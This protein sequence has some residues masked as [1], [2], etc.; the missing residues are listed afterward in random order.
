MIDTKKLLSLLIVT[1][2]IISI[3]VL[4]SDSDAALDD[5]LW[6]GDHHI[7]VSANDS[8]DGWVYTHANNKLTLTNATISGYHTDSDGQFGFSKNSAAIYDGRADSTLSIELIGNNVISGK[9]AGADN[10]CGIIVYSNLVISGN[11]SLTIN[12][13]RMNGIIV[14]DMF[15][16]NGSPTINI[17]GCTNYDLFCSISTPYSPE[18]KPFSDDRGITTNGGT[19]N[20]SGIIDLNGP[21]VMHEGTINMT[22]I[23]DSQIIGF[24]YKTLT[25][26]GGRII[27]TNTVADDLIIAGSDPL[28]LTG[29]TNENVAIKDGG[30]G[31]YSVSAADVFI[32]FPA[33]SYTVTFDANG[34]TGTMSPVSDVSGEY[35]LPECTFTA[36]E[37]KTFK[38]WSV[39]DTEKSVGDKI[40]VT[41]NT[42]LKAVWKDSSSS[43]GG[44][45]PIG[46]VIGAVVG[47]IAVVG[48]GFFVLKKI[49]KI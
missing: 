14:D 28:V 8:G 4:S 15:T 48:I 39:G 2:C 30:C 25:M 20:L 3:V 1:A 36:P 19:F 29:A 9:D 46:I 49:G 18:P 33:S 40:T 13:P 22:N 43:S 32:G 6:V 23:A 7:N 44:S 21:M 24:T 11:G 37:G 45:F 10:T 41:E 26:D 42:T 31:L 17:D 34:G 38:C 47:V 27:V 16:V 5:G 12:G 35:T